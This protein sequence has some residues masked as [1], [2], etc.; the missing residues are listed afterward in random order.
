MGD[1]MSYHIM[2]EVTK[3][4]LARAIDAACEREL[5]AHREA[6]KPK[7]DPA[8]AELIRQ[9]QDAAFIRCQNEAMMNCAQ[10]MQSIY[11]Q[12]LGNPYGVPIL[13]AW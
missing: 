2:A 7:P 13:Y 1:R 5:A 4:R 9:Q 11:G 6:F 10:Q 8:V 3:K 12:Q